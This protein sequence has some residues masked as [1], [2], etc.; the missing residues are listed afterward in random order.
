MTAIRPCSAWTGL[1]RGRWPIIGIGLAVLT[2]A[3][4]AEPVAEAATFTRPAVSG[5]E[6]LWQATGTVVPGGIA[7]VLMAASE[8]L[9]RNV[10]VALVDPASGQ[11]LGLAQAFR[12]PGSAS[13]NT[14]WIALLG[15]P[16][17]VIPGTY[18]LV[19]KT[20][21]SGGPIQHTA[22]LIVSARPFA[23]LEI[24]LSASLTALRRAPDPR[25]DEQSRLLNEVLLGF[26][27]AA[28]FHLEALRLPLVELRRTSA[29]G[30]RRSYL[31]HDGNS[32]L[33]V[34]SGIDFAANRGTPVTASGGGRVAMARPRIVTGNTV[35]LEHL[36]G[37]FSLYYH[38]D[39][40]TV[41]E[42]QMLEAGAPVGTVGS[43]GLATGAHLH[44]EVRVG[45]VAVD[46]M[47][48][49]AERLVDT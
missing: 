35:V 9:Q 32:S 30:D 31:Y 10:L 6:L 13:Q 39:S 7:R 11:T 43:T 3:G 47:L 46:P 33:S 1:R 36:P 45:G 48:L 38:L 37:V 27:E 15:I 44:W 20:T 42:G 19:M 34:H 25:K 26:D 24:A 2:P 49:L 14:G 18:E 22:T 17:T 16:T 8:P 5:S 28:A 41:G 23:T 29:Y 21:E 4:V 12:A 40:M